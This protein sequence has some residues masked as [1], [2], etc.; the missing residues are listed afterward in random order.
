M[1]APGNW[2]M[3]LYA[4]GECLPYADN[5]VALNHDKKTSGQTHVTINCE[6]KENERSMNKDISNTAAEILEAA[7]FKDIRVCN[8]ISFPGNANHEMEQHEW[9]KTRRH[10]CS[11]PITKC[12]Q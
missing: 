7:G 8:T 11:M 6:F 5:R 4:F 1:S 12:T 3:S 2:Q 10:L 9:A